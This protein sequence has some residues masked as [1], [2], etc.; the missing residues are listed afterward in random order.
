MEFYL[1]FKMLFSREW[2]DGDQIHIQSNSQEAK[3]VLKLVVKGTC[4]Q[5]LLQL[6][7]RNF[8]KDTPIELQK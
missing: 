2:C 7:R 1:N 3:K 5:A 8:Q 6:L 4:D